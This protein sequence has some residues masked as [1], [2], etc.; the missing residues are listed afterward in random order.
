[1]TAEK[2]DPLDDL[3]LSIDMLDV[4][5]LRDWARLLLE[6][7]ADI[8][9]WG[10][11]PFVV[12]KMQIMATE[13]EKAIRDIGVLRAE[14]AALSLSPAPPN[15]CEILKAFD[16]SVAGVHLLDGPRPNYELWDKA[17]WHTRGI[18]QGLKIARTILEEVLKLP[19]PPLPSEKVG[20]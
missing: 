20:E 6:H 15:A 11:V 18:S 10:S 4:D 14:R 9:H 1:M 2:N 16:F 5:R 12:G 13:M 17:E 8:S 19:A 3:G 7:G